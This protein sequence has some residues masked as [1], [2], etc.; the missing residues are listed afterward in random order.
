MDFVAAVVAAQG[1]RGRGVDLQPPTRSLNFG[2]RGQ[3]GHRLA[4]TGYGEAQ[5]P[6]SPHCL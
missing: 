2:E 3:E 4:V 5:H 6:G 1:G